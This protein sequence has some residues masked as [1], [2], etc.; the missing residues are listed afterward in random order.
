MFL[1]FRLRIGERDSLVLDVLLLTASTL[2]QRPMSL[3]LRGSGGIRNT[4]TLLNGCRRLEVSA[5]A[6]WH[7]L[8][9]RCL[10]IYYLICLIHL[11]LLVV[12]RAFRIHWTPH[13][14]DF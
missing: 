11:K 2:L 3:V 10:T 6:R 4:D 9:K 7:T 13:W 1:L 5:V 14:D 12:L 8:S